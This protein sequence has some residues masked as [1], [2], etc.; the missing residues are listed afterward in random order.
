L[1]CRLIEPHGHWLDSGGLEYA[2]WRNVTVKAEYI[3]V[4]LDSDSVTETA[5]VVDDP[6]SDK[7]ASFNANFGRTNINVVRV[8]LNYR[9]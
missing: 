1:L 3:Y 8:G 4:S 2:L 9:F 6:Q 7:P 5:L